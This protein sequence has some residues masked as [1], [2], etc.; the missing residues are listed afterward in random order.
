MWRC[1]LNGPYCPDSLQGVNV[2]FDD[3]F[4]STVACLM[5]FVYR[6][7]GSL[8]KEPVVVEGQQLK[9]EQILSEPEGV[10]F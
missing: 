2:A 1:G 9:H 4:I 3:L 6:A 5:D 8:G 7:D 10:Y